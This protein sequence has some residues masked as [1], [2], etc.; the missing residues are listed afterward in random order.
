MTRL[1]IDEVIDEV[2]AAARTGAFVLVAPPGAG[3]TTRVPPALLDQIKGQI[4]VLEPRRVAARAAAR[5][6]AFER[7]EPVG[8]TVGVQVRF[9]RTGGRATRI[10]VVTDGILLRRL[11][12][13]PLLDGIGAVLIDEV[14]ERGLEVDLALALLAEVRDAR[15]ELV[16]GAMSA[17]IDPGPLSAFLG[18]APVV[19]SEG[20]TYPVDVAWL[21]HPDPRPTED[22]VADGIRRVLSEGDGDVLVFLPGVREIR[23]VGE[24]LAG[25][26]VDVVPLYGDL[27]PDAQ[28]AALSPGPRRR[29]VLATNVAETSV[30]VPGVTV[31]VDSGLVRRPRRD[32]ATG[33]DHLDTVPISR[34]SADQRAGRAGRTAPGRALRLWTERE[35]RG[36]AP[37]DPPEVHR[38]DLAG[39]VLHLLAWGADPRRFR[40]LDPPP[41][42][43][44]DAALAVLRELGAVDTGITA[45]GRTLASLPLHPRLGRL[46]VEAARYGHGPDGALAAALLSERD[47]FRSVLP[48]VV[49]PSDVLD[50]L[51]AL[52]EGRGDPNVRRNLMRTA[53]ALRKTSGALPTVRRVDRDEALMRAVLAAWPDRVVRRRAP[54]SDRGRM[55]GGKGVRLDRMSAVTAAELF[56][57]VD[58]EADG[59]DARV[60]IA[61]AVAPEWL[62]TSEVDALALDDAGVVRAR[63]STRYRDLELGSH[64]STVDR[65]RAAELLAEV[66]TT[67]IA[68]LQPTDPEFL[69]LR[70]RLSCLAVWDPAG[71]WD[72]DWTQVLPIVCHDRRS[73]AEVRGADWAGAVRTVLGHRAWTEL[74]RL[75][76]ERIEVP[77]GRR[78]AIAYEPGSP[79]S[80]AV[81]I[82]ELFGSTRTPSVFGG[83]IPVRLHLLA[84]N[85]RPQQITDDLAGFWA[86][87]WPEVRRELRARYP[88][89]AWP[90]DPLT[91]PPQTRPRRPR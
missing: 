77:S 28:D 83:K 59:A 85:G 55:V 68:E 71:P 14:H 52:V 26:P 20:R 72:L 67:R 13:D 10:W 23:R 51:D 8:A 60:R 3:K 32:P 57:A 12:E 84:P 36:R 58:L 91:A 44:I 21:V 63:R 50:R 73:F 64:P 11:Q 40:W 4:W 70:T 65:V 66:A 31:V 5:R 19:Q 18:D 29:V 7:G 38:V 39:P 75:A 45:L 43:A 16:V 41:P 49:S 35:H 33:L 87:T 69:S 80:V 88:K 25:L 47:P 34:A 46:L 54:E 2:R 78:H 9:E 61:S 53:D 62:A 89:H 27:P 76:P 74:E 86:R 24:R 79:P 48:T 30:T 17:T 37:F 90:E 1:P 22:V 6:M 56:V 15:P 82:Q 42:D 81:Q